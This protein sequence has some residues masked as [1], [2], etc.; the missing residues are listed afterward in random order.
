[1]RSSV[2]FDNGCDFIFMGSV[3]NTT[4]DFTEIVFYNI[5]CG[6][7]RGRPDLLF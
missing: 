5:H 4:Y 3:T 6:A 7:L 1:M 2:K